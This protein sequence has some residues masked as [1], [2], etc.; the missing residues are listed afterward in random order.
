MS[1][2]SWLTKNF[3]TTC[4]FALLCVLCA[5]FF[6]KNNNLGLLAASAGGSRQVADLP[7]VKIGHLPYLPAASTAS[8]H[9]KY[10]NTCISIN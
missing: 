3:D 4:F 5:I 6:V 10:D 8:Y 2:V 9:T 7:P 1:N